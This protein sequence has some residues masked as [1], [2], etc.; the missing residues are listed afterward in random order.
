MG[1]NLQ[2][3]LK[4]EIMN[5][6]K[7]LLLV[8]SICMVS[9]LY[10]CIAEPQAEVEVTATSETEIIPEKV[11][12]NKEVKDI[13][14]VENGKT[15][16]TIKYTVVTCENNA[17]LQNSL[18]ELNAKMKKDAEDFKSE[19]AADIRSFI[20]DNPDM[21]EAEYAHTSDITFVRQ[22]E[23][24]ACFIEFVY[25]NTMGAH[26]MYYQNGHTYDVKTG[27]KLSIFDFVKDKEELRAFLKKWI[28]DNNDEYGF[29]NEA[30]NVIDSYI[31]GEYELQ[32]YVNG[33]LTV[34]FQPYDVA[35]Y[36]AG[37][38]EVK[39]D[40]NLLKVDLGDI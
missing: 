22:D 7:V 17:V 25:V 9:L 19:N 37:L 1:Y 26:G 36:A 24:Y 33:D 28:Q 32:F 38:I 11:V 4:G 34:I 35:P 30:P 31:N 12:L 8:L 40:K 23:K 5:L 10:G 2:V 13:S 6:K 20:K 21:Q 27:A 3:E 39:I 18:D 16:Q 15:Y 29:F 14:D